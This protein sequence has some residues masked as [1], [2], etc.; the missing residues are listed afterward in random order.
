[1]STRTPKVIIIGGPNGAGKSTLAPYLLK[2]AFG[3]FEYVNA[4]TIALGLSAFSPETVAFEAGRVMLRR[5]RDLAETSDDFAFES[6]L[7]SRFYVRWINDLKKQGYSFH[8]IY[9]WLRSPEL[10]IERVRERV[11]LGGHN[12]PEE[13][14][15]RRYLKGLRNLF[16]LY[17]PLADTWAI[18]DNSVSGD[19]I[20]IA[21]GKRDEMTVSDEHL[22]QEIRERL[23]NEN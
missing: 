4:D 13:I 2:D 11:R 19:P 12:V 3:L 16:A 17:Q 21:A 1:M 22:W 15:H 10:A 8:L 9:L 7:A 14:I 23:D 18:Y 6:T 20:L 5:L